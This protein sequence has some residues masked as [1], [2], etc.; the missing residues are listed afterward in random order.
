MPVY[1]YSCPVCDTD[2]DRI[3]KIADRDAQHCGD[4]GYSLVR[5]I[6]FNGATWAPTSTGGGMKV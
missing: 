3:V 4:C 1:Q 5:A 2:E 6:V